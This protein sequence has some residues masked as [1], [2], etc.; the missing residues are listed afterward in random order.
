MYSPPKSTEPV[1]FCKIFSSLS[2]LNY[3]IL[4]HS[5]SQ[6][7]SDPFLVAI[8]NINTSL[9]SLSTSIHTRTTQLRV[10]CRS[11]PFSPRQRFKTSLF[12]SK[13]GHMELDILLNFPVS[14]VKSEQFFQLVLITFSQFDSTC[15]M[16]V[17][18]TF[19]SWMH[20]GDF[21]LLLST[22]TLSIC[23]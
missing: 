11:L 3:F 4:L 22:D 17:Y 18:I 21:L 15:L 20:V 6:T 13:L 1:R 8:S 5:S 7:Q 10:S 2:S 14:E 12:S 16:F 9:S 23:F 19:L